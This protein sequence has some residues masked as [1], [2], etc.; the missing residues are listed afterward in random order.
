MSNSTN[1]IQC[2]TPLSS[3]VSHSFDA[4][5]FTI[6]FRRIQVKAVAIIRDFKF[7]SVGI[8]AKDRFQPP[9]PAMLNGVVDRFSRYLQ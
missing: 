9:R 7:H 6:S 1:N 2:T 3:T 4:V 5:P 8:P